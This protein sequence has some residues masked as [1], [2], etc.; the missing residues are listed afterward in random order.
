MGCGA[1]QDPC[2]TPT[3]DLQLW[4]TCAVHTPCIIIPSHSPFPRALSQGVPAGCKE[5]LVRG[6]WLRDVMQGSREMK[7][8]G[9]GVLE[10]PPCAFVSQALLWL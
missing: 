1:V 3:C 7:G 8:E 4:G 9:R 5:R 10:S 2:V 6:G